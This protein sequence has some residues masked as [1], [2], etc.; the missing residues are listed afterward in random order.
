MEG[1]TFST[2]KVDCRRSFESMQELSKNCFDAQI[3]RGPPPRLFRRPGR[4]EAE[5]TCWQGERAWKG[6][7]L[8]RLVEQAENG[9]PSVYAGDWRRRL[10]S[11]AW[12]LPARPQIVRPQLRQRQFADTKAL[13]M[14]L[15]WHLL[16]RAP[17][18]GAVESRRRDMAGPRTQQTSI[19]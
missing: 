14:Q 10:R 17:K 7:A 2:P 15:P 18:Q 8:G 3:H 4:L 19:L 1:L 11:R 12:R 6:R 13:R 9:K 16:N 5:P